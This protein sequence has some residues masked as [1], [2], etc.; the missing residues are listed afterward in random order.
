MA[1]NYPLYAPIIQQQSMMP[2]APMAPSQYVSPFDALKK[3]Q[4]EMAGMP[5]A[6]ALGQAAGMSAAQ[7]S[8]MAGANAGSSAGAGQLFA[9][10][11][12]GGF[13]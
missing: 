8:G 1:T 10:R 13:K 4:A 3:K 5:N 7:S 9:S 11:I 2:I 6:Q 12:A